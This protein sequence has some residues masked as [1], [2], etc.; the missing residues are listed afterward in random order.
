VATDRSAGQPTTLLFSFNASRRKWPSHILIEYARQHIGSS[1]HWLARAEHVARALCT[2]EPA[3]FL[4][5]LFRCHRWTGRVRTLGFGSRL[6]Q[7]SYTCFGFASPAVRADFEVC[8]NAD[9]VSAEGR[10]D[11]NLK[12]QTDYLTDSHRGRCA[13]GQAW[14]P[15]ET[16]LHSLLSSGENTMQAT[17][18][19]VEGEQRLQVS[20]GHGD[21]RQIDD[22]P[23]RCCCLFGE[24]LWT[25][26]NAA[27]ADDAVQNARSLPTNT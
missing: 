9:V 23:S 10:F 4:Q 27:N 15:L 8:R 3:C 1:A 25:P 13:V 16:R 24:N 18:A 5:I 2:Q 14:S 21:V 12:L 17:E 22:V 20:R 11:F 7:L 19:Q 26:G 6:L